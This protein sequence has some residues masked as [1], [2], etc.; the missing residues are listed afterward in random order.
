MSKQKFTI[1]IAIASLILLPL[2]L[3][4]QPVGPKARGQYRWRDREKENRKKC[5]ILMM[6]DK[7]TEELPDLLNLR[8]PQIDKYNEIKR[9]HRQNLKEIC[10]Q[11]EQERKSFKKDLESI[12]TPEQQEKLAQLQKKMRKMGKARMGKGKGRRRMPHPRLIA[13]AIRQMNLPEDKAREIKE[14][15]MNARDRAKSVD[16][17]DKKELRAIFTDMIEQIKQVLS[18]EEYER[19]KDIVRDL[20]SQQGRFGTRQSGRRRGPSHRGY[21]RGAERGG[22]DRWDRPRFGP[23][24]GR[25]PVPPPERDRENEFLW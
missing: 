3:L 6:Y 7:I 9:Q 22:Y 4:A 20:Q 1:R 17:R 10:K 19:L 5:P 25:G 23:D 18:P 8:E 13:Q 24:G 21:D 2:M 16:R 15:L 12:L 14:I 11:L